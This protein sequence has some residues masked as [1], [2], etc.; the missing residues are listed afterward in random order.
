MKLLE[1]QWL[2]ALATLP[3]LASV[4]IAAHA[5]QR[6]DVRKF[7]GAMA[8]RV[9]LS[10]RVG[11]ARVLAAVALLLGL[12]LVAAALARPVY[13]PKPQKV[14]RT[15]RDVVFV[16]DVS[17]SM[18]AEDIKPNRLERAKLAVRDVLE[19][20]QGD[21]VAIIAFAGSA[22]TVCPLTTDYAFAR[23]ALDELSPDSV[24][25]GGTAIADALRSATQLLTNDEGSSGAAPSD[26]FRDLFLFTDGE[27][28][29]SDP[30]KAAAAAKELGVR[31]IA[32]GLGSETVG[33]IVPKA[34][35]EEPDPMRRPS[36]QS[37]G[38]M[39]YRGERVQ[40]RLDPDSLRKIAAAA[41]DGSLFFNVGTGNIE[42]DRV[43]VQLM[44]SSERRSLDTS[45]AVKYTE[46]FQIALTAALLMLFTESTLTLA[47]RRL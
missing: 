19:V 3:V 2:L 31:V 37:Q 4:W 20:V 44:K 36:P 12:A 40:S 43:Y 16:I 33:A 41:A 35:I 32:I 21:R 47:R 25:R 14:T 5:K 30:V 42:L 1:P 26:R 27:D 15:G 38:Y 10:E 28:H 34:S 39:E 23:L 13:D 17:R 18:L 7:F 6:R 29:E 9:G 46:G 24:A 45:E 11:A 22:L 8:T